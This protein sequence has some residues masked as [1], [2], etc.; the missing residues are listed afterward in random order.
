MTGK[1]KL[2]AVALAVAVV[3][4]GSVAQGQDNRFSLRVSAPKADCVNVPVHTAIKLGAQLADVPAEEVAVVVK[5]QGQTGAEVPGQIVIGQQGETQLWWIMPQAKA[6]EPSTWVATLTKT[7]Q[8]DQKA[9]SFSDKPGD[10]LDLLFDGRKVTR[11][12]YAY[13]NSTPERLQ[14]TNKP[15]HHVFDA[16]GEKLITHGPPGGLYPHHRGIFIGWHDVEFEG[17]KYDFWAMTGGWRDTLPTVQV[18]RKFLDKTAGPVLASS[19]MLVHWNDAN[20]NTIITEQRKVTVFA[21]EAPTILLLDFCSEL[22]AVAGDVFLNGDPEH[23]GMQY[24]PHNDVAAGSKTAEGGG[25]ATYLF[26]KDGIDP[27]K[28][29]NLPWTAMSYPLAD[30][31]FSVQHIDHPDNPNP[32]LYSAYRNYGRFGAFFKRKLNAGETVSARYRIWV[33]QGQMPPREEM[34]ARCSAFA[35]PPQVQVLK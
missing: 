27:H 30:Q 16:K 7:P 17:K 10:Y 13:D 1:V 26:H 29:Q 18:H 2:L 8:Q 33:G 20:D 25:T 28:D 35:E 21:Q 9:F 5:E 6:N 31:F 11:Y 22:K 14:Q 24:R 23:G 34:S 19:Q 3:V 15:Y 12:M 32:T 4:A